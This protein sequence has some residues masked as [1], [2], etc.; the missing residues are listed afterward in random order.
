MS[1]KAR[2]RSATGRLSFA[3]ATPG[4][5]NAI[6]VNTVNKLESARNPAMAAKAHK[7]VSRATSSAS[8][9]SQTS[10]SRRGSDAGYIVA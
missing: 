1:A 5:F 2:H 7:W 6:R 8:L 3:K 10:G 9:S 4:P